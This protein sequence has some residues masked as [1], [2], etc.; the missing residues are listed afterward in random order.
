MIRNQWYGVLESR[1][2]KRGQVRGVTRMGEKLVLWRRPD[3]TLSCLGDLCAHR[4]VAL[5]AGRLCHG[6]IQCP[7]HGLEYDV[8]GRCVLIPANGR[9]APVPPTVPGAILPCA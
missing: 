9:K 1:E 2:I 6:N 5:S 8:S 3:G 7:F 4:G